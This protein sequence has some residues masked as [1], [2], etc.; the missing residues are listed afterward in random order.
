[1]F[2]S[3]FTCVHN[4]HC[5]ALPHLPTI[6]DTWTWPPGNYVSRWVVSQVA[7]AMA[8]AQ[9]VIFVP[10]ASA[11][12]TLEK[13][14]LAAGLFAIFCFS[15]VGAICDNAGDPQCRGNDAI[16]SG[17]AITFF[18]GYNF[19][20]FTTSWQL[21]LGPR[22]GDVVDG[23]TSQSEGRSGCRGC[24]PNLLRRLVPSPSTMLVALAMLSTVAKL[25]YVPQVADWMRQQ[26]A[27]TS[28]S[29]SSG[30][31]GGGGG[32]SLGEGVG[33]VND[34]TPLAI[35]EWTDVFGI[36][37]WT[38]IYVVSKRGTFQIQIRDD[39][40]SSSSSSTTP[41]TAT[42]TTTTTT[43]TT[44]T[45][46]T[47]ARFSAKSLAVLV[48]VLFYTT[49]LVCL[50]FAFAQKRVPAGSWP[51]ISDTFVYP[52]GNWISRWSLNFAGTVAM[53]GQLVL[54]W[55][56]GKT[57]NVAKAYTALSIV[58][59]VGLQIV[60]C[61]DEDENYPIHIAAAVVFFGGYDVF[62]VV[63]SSRMTAAR[64]WGG[65]GAGRKQSTPSL[66]NPSSFGPGPCVRHVEMA[67]AITSCV[68]TIIRFWPF[69]TSSPAIA[70]TAAMTS[71]M[72]A[73]TAAAT[74]AAAATDS[75]GGV[76]EP[77]IDLVV[78]ICEWLDA[79]SLVSYTTLALLA[80]GK[81][82][83]PIGVVIVGPATT[84]TTTTTTTTSRASASASSSEGTLL[85][86]GGAYTG[87]NDL[88][89]SD[90]DRYGAYVGNYGG[91]ASGASGASGD[92]AP[93]APP[94]VMLNG[95]SHFNYTELTETE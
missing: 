58:S 84:T 1:M 74:A 24:C 86:Q 11:Q 30:G 35:V 42:A 76:G 21:K 25:R 88:R 43:A 39:G 20:M 9:F 87:G 33:G 45:D 79:V 49:L 57:D 3:Y 78:A 17:F 68:L 37:L 75:V 34:Q 94:L 29:S 91:G 15:W 93:S 36:I 48:V 61:V 16:H 50:A 46:T 6:S 67:L 59:L 71:T 83:T 38:V 92:W 69:P 10:Q 65:K 54:Y 95:P 73:T 51:M 52:P 19:N 44:N 40:N 72:N 13:V 27:T 66:K 81:Q 80:Y 12:P 4:G 63:R 60:G 70:A 26:W 7:L 22:K 62:M 2:V 55:L 28:S 89:W 14:H 77:I 64:W 31:G 8:L 53:A 82:L 18:I 90:G 85:E 23:S 41:T 56:D 5:P 32:D 47:I